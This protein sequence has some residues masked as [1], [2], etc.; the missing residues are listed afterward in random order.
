MPASIEQAIDQLKWVIPTHYV[1]QPTL[2]RKVECAGLVKVAGVKVASKSR[3]VERVSAVE[4]KKD[5]LD[6]KMDI[7]MGML[8]QLLARPTRSPSPFPVRKQCFNC[9]EI[10]HLSQ[11]FPHSI[12]NVKGLPVIF[13]QI[14]S[15]SMSR[16]NA[17]GNGVAIQAVIDT[18]A[19]NTLIS[20]W[21]I[22]QLPEKVP[23]VEQVHKHKDTIDGVRAALGLSAQVVHIALERNRAY[24]LG[25]GNDMLHGS[26]G[27]LW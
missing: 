5:M 27:A 20:D 21:I 2:V 22:A 15:D 14:K 4:R 3:L 9:K 11:E 23:M 16:I 12:Q 13:G 1:H 25:K 26:R 24:G 8:D 19:G 6:E 7:C 10:G 17:R 18:A